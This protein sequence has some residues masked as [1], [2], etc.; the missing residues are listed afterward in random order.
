MACI[1]NGLF[2]CKRESNF[3]MCHN[4]DESWKHCA[5]WNKPDTKGQI[6]NIVGFYL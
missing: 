5:K 1:H 2:S 4:V 6:L 3:D